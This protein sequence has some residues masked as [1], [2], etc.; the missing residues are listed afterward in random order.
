MPDMDIVEGSIAAV[1]AAFSGWAAWSAMKAAKSSDRNSQTANRTAELAYQTAESVAQIERNRWH[2]DLTPQISFRIDDERGWPDLMVRYTAPSGISRLDSVELRVR[3]DR[4]REEDPVLA[5]SLTPEE[6]RATIWGPY[7]FRIYDH[8]TEAEGIG[9]IPEPFSL[10]R[11]DVQRLT[12]EATF[13]HSHYGG[14]STEWEHHYAGEPLR[15]WIVC[16][17]EGHKP[18][19]LTVDVPEQTAEYGVWT[20][21]Q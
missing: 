4:N 16:R 9:R 13:P 20:L 3:D 5:G 6:R 11:G 19:E 12:L 7:R 2:Q 1:A 8:S 14:G 17:A 10:A 18:W 21:A 15:L